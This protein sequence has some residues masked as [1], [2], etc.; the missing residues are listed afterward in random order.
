MTSDEKLARIEGLAKQLKLPIVARFQ[1]HIAKEAG[2][3]DNLLR[4]LELELL[5]K[6]RRG[7]ERRTKMA[8]FP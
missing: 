4:L 1:E 6:E 8:G 5:D 2:L 3:D 7:I